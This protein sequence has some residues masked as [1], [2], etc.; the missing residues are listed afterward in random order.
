MDLE[1]RLSKVSAKRLITSLTA[2]A[3]VATLAIQTGAPAVGAPPL[4][5]SR[6][7]DNSRG[8]NA[9]SSSGRHMLSK[10]GKISIVTA[11][12]DICMSTPASCEPTANL[13]RSIRPDAALTM[14]DNQY[15]SGTIEE[16]R[17]S[18]AKAW[19]RFKAITRPSPG[20]H[21]WKD[22]TNGYETYFGP[23]VQTN[24]NNWYSFDLG[25]WHLVSLDGTCSALP[26]ACDAGGA[27]YHW[28]AK[29]L[30]T[31]ASRCTLAYWHEPRW[32][33]GTTHGSS[34]D[35]GAL[36]QLLYAAGAEIVLNGHE[37]N[38]ERFAPQTPAGNLDATKGITEIVAGTGGAENGSYPFGNPIA[39]SLIRLN[40]VGVVKLTLRAKGWK[41]QFV[42]PSGTVVDSSSGTCH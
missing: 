8:G 34:T 5:A 26:G 18:Y 24:G 13:V 1:H 42:R 10:A 6:H 27:E 38:Y 2:G 37:H 22:M 16:Y 39:N 17:A 21:E 35:V 31:H 19:G 7:R 36:W 40:G 14:G 12:G 28:L 25:N 9:R 33:S 29:D 23:A 20:N 32:S 15:S 41:E 4:F 3:I 30:S 11:A